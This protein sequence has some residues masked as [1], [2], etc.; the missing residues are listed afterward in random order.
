MNKKA[1]LLNMVSNF[2]SFAVQLGISFFL[3]PYIIKTLSS[4]AYGFVSLANSFPS[5]A[6]LITAAINGMA[7]R[8]VSIEIFKRKYDEANK[9]FS[10]VFISN[11]VLVVVWI[12]FS[13]IFIV[14]IN[15]F[16]DVPNKLLN[17]VKILFAVIFAN[18]GL[19]LLGNI[20]NVAIFTENKLY[21]SSIRSVEALLIKSAL[22]VVLFSFFEPKIYYLGIC[23]TVELLFTSIYNLYYTKKFLPFMKIKRKFFDKKKV[24]ELI[25]SGIWNCIS[26]L[27]G[28]LNEGLDM[29]ICNL[30]IGAKSMGVL[31][32]AKTIPAMILTLINIVAN[33]FSP[34]LTK[35][36]TLEGKTQLANNIKQSMKIMGVIISVPLGGI[37][38]FG[39][40][41]FSLWVPSE[42]PVELQKISI[43]SICLLIFTSATSTIYNVFTITNKLKLNSIVTVVVGF[44]NT[45]VVFVLLKT[46]DLG[47]YAIA[48]VSSIIGILRD[49]LFSI[50][51]AAKCLNVKKRLFY[52]PALKS[53]ISVLLVL[54]IC[55]LYKNIF[56]M[57]SWLSLVIAAFVCGMLGYILNFFLM[58][59]KEDRNFVLG[60]LKRKGKTSEIY[61]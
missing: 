50:P 24:G 37:V 19:S 31:S 2:I 38:G 42:N 61:N 7:C 1:V 20:L 29:L 55:L 8:F 32:I 14:N 15:T 33:A 28:V 52:F 23:A 54:L 53:A 9:F 16:L 4:E 3:T 56:T 36:Y 12:V 45:I 35:S 22:L 39:E 40:T 60:I 18:F 49:Y 11:V 25:S 47:L 43:L 57:N 41:F 46:T 5:Y 44:I 51:Y 34:D 59:K 26:R 13:I 17:D 21:L 58:L 6:Q 48:G 30:L 27:G 10:S